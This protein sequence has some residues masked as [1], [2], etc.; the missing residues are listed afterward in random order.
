MGYAACG[1]EDG[2]LEGG[3]CQLGGLHHE[4]RHPSPF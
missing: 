3:V 4:L 1:W 2:Y